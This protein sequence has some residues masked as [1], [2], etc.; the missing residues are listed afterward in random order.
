MKK[1]LLLLAIFLLNFNLALALEDGLSY[2]VLPSGQK[3]VIKEVK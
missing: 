2:S 3:V 1:I